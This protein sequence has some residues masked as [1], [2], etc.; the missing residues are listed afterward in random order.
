MTKYHKNLLI[1]ILHI[2]VLWGFAVAQPLYDLLAQY[3]EFFIARNSTPTDI[4]LFVSLLSVL[5][6]LLFGLLEV[7][8]E[9][10]NTR[11]RKILHYLIIGFLSASVAMQ[12]LKKM[13][14]L[15]D[16]ILLVLPLLAGGIF[17]VGYIRLKR[18]RSYVTFLCPAIL[19]FPA[20]FLFFSP[21]HQILIPQS[22]Q[23]IE[24]EKKDVTIQNTPPIIFII[25][26]EFPLTS[27]MDENRRI[28]SIRYPNFA[29]LAKD[30]YWFREFTVSSPSTNISI[31]MILTGKY[32]RDYH[33]MTA[34]EYP[35]SLFT[36]LADSYDIV[37]FESTGKMCPEKLLKNKKQ[38]SLGDRTFSLWE[39]LHIVYLHVILPPNFSN[40]LPPVTQTWKNFGQ[41][42][43]KRNDV[44]Q[45]LEKNRMAEFAEFVNSIK[46]SPKPTLYFLHTLLPHVP[47]EYLP[48]GKSYQKHSIPG[49]NL[50]KEMWGNN[51]WLIVQAYQRH[52]L[53]VG[54]TDKMVGKLIQHLKKTGLYD[55]SLIIITADH[56]CSFQANGARRGSKE[57]LLK[58]IMPVPLII[59]LPGQDKGVINDDNVESIDILPTIS[60]VLNIKIP[61]SVDG[62]STLS[63]S[64]SNRPQKTMIVGNYKDGNEVME[65]TYQ[66]DKDAKYETLDWKLSI[67]GTGRTK[68]NGYF[69][70][71]A[72]GNLV[73][74]KIDDSDQTGI[75]NYKMRLDQSF[76]FD[77]VDLENPFFAPCFIS[78]DII[79]PDSA[80]RPDYLAISVNEKIQVVTQTYKIAFRPLHFYG[81]I[82]EYALQNGRNN[83]HVFAVSSEENGQIHLS[84]IQ[85]IKKAYSFQSKHITSFNGKKIK[86]ISN[87]I[88]GWVRAKKKQEGFVSF[89]GWA[90]DI[91]N[92]RLVD[93]VLV[94]VNGKFVFS[95]QERSS[96]RDVG[97]HFK[98]PKLNNCGFSFT[99]PSAMFKDAIDVQLYAILNGTTSE[100]NYTDE[101]PWKPKSR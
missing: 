64:P 50:K 28:D 34:E 92:S 65:F 85:P 21:V 79:V 62:C 94:F 93:A 78:G 20:F 75:S 13:E 59:K 43:V 89:S 97:K 82:P 49:L 44:K 18:L 22:I 46:V 19:I 45:K 66:L 35:N 6:P 63:R 16:I 84:L 90:A 99:L 52:L 95:N 41:S 80:K 70:F 77:N 101:Y 5:F 51:Q 91:E 33:M 23:S 58:D 54:A 39:D 11:F 4:I 42:S 15:F 8:L 68:P 100:L 3:P 74:K 9:L 10:I 47:W 24:I 67:F 81:I 32:I 83:I 48:S 73:G 31:P 69:R 25:F 76:L 7:L 1:D 96:R 36:L 27:L 17:I 14:Y 30:S 29:E 37:A 86:I 40:I 61:W 60:D 98:N 56:G 72:Y 87:A 88:K 12:T 53:Q 2:M 55:Q 71:G 57:N 26:D 38:E